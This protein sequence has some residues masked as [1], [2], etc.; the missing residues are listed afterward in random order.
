M[1][2]IPDHETHKV[3]QDSLT[4]VKISPPLQT[5]D[6]KLFIVPIETYDASMCGPLV[7][8]A[9]AKVVPGIASHWGVVMEIR[10]PKGATYRVLYHLTF[11]EWQD[12]S[13]GDFHRKVALYFKT[14]DTTFGTEVGTTCEN[15]EN[16]YE[17]G[18]KLVKE[19]GSYHHVFWNCRLFLNCFL[20]ILTKSDNDFYGYF[21]AERSKI[22]IP[23]FHLSADIRPRKSNQNVPLSDLKAL[24]GKGDIGILDEISQE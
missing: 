7:T 6:S 16:V 8:A 18:K 15:M 1:D 21:P 11:E 14:I 12:E 4:L 23:A 13:P 22:F 24:L 5:S 17:I 2:N 9:E 10:R 20:R 19:F 3:I